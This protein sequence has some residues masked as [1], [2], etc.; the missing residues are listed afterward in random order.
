MNAL[1]KA[2]LRPVDLL[3]MIVACAGA[4]ALTWQVMTFHEYQSNEPPAAY[5]PVVVR[6]LQQGKPVMKVVLWSRVDDYRGEPGFTLD[7]PAGPLDAAK[8]RRE[9]AGASVNGKVVPEGTAMR[10]TVSDDDGNNVFTSEYRVSN[11]RLTPLR[12]EVHNQGVVFWMLC[13]GVAGALAMG[14]LMPLLR[15]AL[16]RQA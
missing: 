3:L 13:A 9:R 4:A 12:H 7:L 11:G 10:V 8:P 1:F 14:M 16:K 2:E 15:R 6:H 5:F